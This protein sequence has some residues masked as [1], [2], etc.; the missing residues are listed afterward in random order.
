M[1][2][3]KTKWLTIFFIW[4]GYLLHLGIENYETEGQTLFIFKYVMKLIGGQ[5]LFIF[6]YVMKL[7][8]ELSQ[9]ATLVVNRWH[10]LHS[11]RSESTGLAVAA[12]MDW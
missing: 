12:L 3:S 9:Q 2:H 8:G 1:T 5:T 4:K 7:I 10:I 6:K 11:Y